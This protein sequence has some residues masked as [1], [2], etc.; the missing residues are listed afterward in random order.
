[1]E[2]Y[3][4]LLKKALNIQPL[5]DKLK[6][7]QI[8]RQILSVF[9]R[10]VAVVL[11]LALLWLWLRMWRGMN[12]VNFLGKLALLIWQAAF[13]YASILVVKILY[14]R[15]AEIM[16]YPDSDYV[17][18]PVIAMLMKTKGQMMLVF[19][20][21]ISV[22]AMLMVWFGSGALCPDSGNAFV[23][24]IVIFILSWMIGFLSLI[25]AQFC[26]EWTLAVFS[27]ASDMSILR[28]NAVPE[29]VN[30]ENTEAV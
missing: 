24:G 16:D 18:V 3:I 6:S 12:D 21:I 11:G 26:A 17:V 27:I 23:S 28:R 25:V 29:K 2:K 20:G 9:Y 30:P 13:L 1:M 8:I 14:V 10:F 5:M 15:A 7:G 22:P 4:T 19:F